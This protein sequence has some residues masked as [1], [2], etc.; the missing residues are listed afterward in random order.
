MSPKKPVQLDPV[1][2]SQVRLS[3]LSILIAVKE[4]DFNTLKRMTG[5]TDGNLSTHLSKLEDS[6]YVKVKKAFKGK[7]PSTSCSITDRGKDAFSEYLK[8]LETI[9]QFSKE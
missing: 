4:A 9:I 6:G 3:I 8:N 1:I 5:A 2:H 7:K